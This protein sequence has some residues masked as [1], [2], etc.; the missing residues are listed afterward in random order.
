MLGV[1]EKA[2]DRS[3]PRHPMPDAQKTPQTAHRHFPVSLTAPLR[4]TT[5][6]TDMK[7]ADVPYAADAEVSLTF[8]ELQ[9]R[10]YYR[11]FFLNA[12]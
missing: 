9:V 3:D 7:T 10:L 12:P 2:V 11:L 1:E 8:D 6:P 5:K 4:S